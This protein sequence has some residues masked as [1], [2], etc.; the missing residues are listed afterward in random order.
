ME[1][2]CDI[3]RAKK[4]KCS[5][6]KPRCAKCN[7]NNWICVYAP[8]V[9]RSPLTRA[10]LTDVE[11]KLNVLQNFLLNLFPGNDINTILKS[12]SIL[13]KSKPE[14]INNKLNKPNKISKKTNDIASIVS[15]DT[16]IG[17]KD[18]T[19][20]NSINKL[21]E[22]NSLEHQNNLNN[23]ME[24]DRTFQKKILN[25]I[26]D[27]N[28]L[29]DDKLNG[30]NWHDNQNIK[31]TKVNNTT[32][33]NTTILNNHDS[34]SNFTIP[35]L[36]NKITH[37]TIIND[38]NN[39]SV[40][41]MNRL[42]LIFNN[43]LSI[44]IY[45]PA[46]SVSQLKSI[47]KYIQ[48]FIYDNP[49]HK[50]NNF[51]GN[52]SNMKHTPSNSNT[53]PNTST[54]NSYMNDLKSQREPFVQYGGNSSEDNKLVFN[55]ILL[56]KNSTRLNYIN[57]FFSFFNKYCP[58]VDEDQFRQNYNDFINNVNNTDTNIS[59]STNIYTSTS[60]S[61]T[62]SAYITK[63][64][65]QINIQN[66]IEWNLL[67]NIILSLGS[68]LQDGINTKNDIY[69]FNIVK[70]SLYDNSINLC[71]NGSI[72]MIIIYHLI[73]V[74]L[75]W[76]DSLHLN[77]NSAYNFNGMA[78][79]LAISLGLNINLD[80][81]F[82]DNEE[83]KTLNEN[84]KNDKISLRR[85]KIIWCALV[86]HEIQLNLH[87]DRTNV[88]NN[89]HFI[90]ADELASK[91]FCENTEK[92]RQNNSENKNG[93][94]QKSDVSYTSFFEI[95]KLYQIF[96]DKLYHINDF[97]GESLSS[98]FHN[99]KEQVLL[100]LK[101]LD[102]LEIDNPIP[103]MNLQLSNF[104]IK[105]FTTINDSILNTDFDTLLSIIKDINKS[106]TK[107]IDSYITNNF[108]QLTP[109]IVWMTVNTIFEFSS[110]LLKFFFY[111]LDCKMDKVNNK[112]MEI[113]Q[114]LKS[115]TRYLHIFKNIN[116]LPQ[117]M[118]DVHLSILENLILEFDQGIIT[119]HNT[120]N[121]TSNTGTPQYTNFIVAN[122]NSDMRSNSVTTF[123]SGII[124]NSGVINNHKNIISD[125]ISSVNVSTP[126]MQHTF[127][128][129]NDSSPHLIIPK[130]GSNT[131]LN[132]LPNGTSMTK[133]D[134]RNFSSDNGNTNNL[135]PLV[136][137]S[138][139][140]NNSNSNSN[141]NS[142][143]TTNI[144]NLYGGSTLNGK[145]PNN[146]RVSPQYNPTRS[147]TDLLNLLSSNKINTTPNGSLTNNNNTL[148]TTGTIN[149]NSPLPTFNN[150]TGSSS[151]IATPGHASFTI[152]QTPIIIPQTVTE[153]FPITNVSNSADYFNLNPNSVDPTNGSVNPTSPFA[154]TYNNNN[155]KMND[156][157]ASNVVAT[158]H[159][160]NTNNGNVNW[161]D[162]TAFNTFGFGNGF[163]NTTTMDDVYNYLFDDNK[164]PTAIS[165][166]PPYGS[167]TNAMYN[168]IGNTVSGSIPDN[169][170][171]SNMNSPKVTQSPTFMKLDTI[172]PSRNLLPNQANTTAMSTASSSS[173]KQPKV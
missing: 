61:N 28:S 160:T 20:T 60:A 44:G 121:S 79:R 80:K 50:M 108:N 139:V 4:L 156:Q 78:L 87:F 77:L 18:S 168:S 98:I 114:I 133:S 72:D 145:M 149:S 37:T 19:T 76:K 99:F 129:A 39:D 13:I 25:P 119:S 6:D 29:P 124:G 8:K 23:D 27:P 152:G 163:F 74:Y 91:M 151:K 10:H 49:L 123:P 141:S 31:L 100:N 47:K 167:N 70:N 135:T 54:S 97:D 36:N 112:S 104:M 138:P 143:S 34:N 95:T 134:Y 122:S 64:E 11:N 96:I 16:S 30:F 65:S 38:L 12:D 154:I 158:V 159:N 73:S 128:N 110:T 52:N 46:S 89:L 106:L 22:I 43:K 155:G 117:S 15:L 150:I 161:N 147:Y 82:T 35:D 81:P 107:I 55:N 120:P 170:R 140:T 105:K 75:T 127:N 71:F 103:L 26:I 157:Q 111:T 24:T 14:I 102:K 69:Y 21:S 62:P 153:N 137:A 53:T 66:T 101:K 85:R 136:S 144:A 17:P 113:F 86:N 88:F 92:E 164:V 172:A 57:C 94:Q 7:K 90:D 142:S 116:F 126:P 68:W 173:L 109:W 32:N 171:N 115:S 48:H 132:F 56:S 45:G 51:S 2:A 5:K 63:I 125:N 83:N 162:S 118:L 67:L 169:S 40:D 3:C 148:T 59:S 84:D 165:N 130:A 93:L 41:M 58:I 33:N 1:Q 131:G 42:K 146:M 166:V 9:K